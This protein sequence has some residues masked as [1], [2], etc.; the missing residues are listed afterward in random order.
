MLFTV[1]LEKQ[2]GTAWQGK[3]ELLHGA[4]KTWG[5][6]VT[7]YES[8]WPIKFCSFCDTVELESCETL[9]MS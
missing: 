5:N 6:R 9:S 4:G 7:N 2:S 1:Q 8:T 3:S